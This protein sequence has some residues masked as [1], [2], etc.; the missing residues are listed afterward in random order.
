[1]TSAERTDNEPE[2]AK[3][4]DVMLSPGTWQR[5]YVRGEEPGP[6]EVDTRMVTEVFHA[7]TGNISLAVFDDGSVTFDG[8]AEDYPADGWRCRWVPFEES[9]YQQFVQNGR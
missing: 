2:P 7:N 8:P 9:A 4:R 6:T 3:V 1:M 5:V